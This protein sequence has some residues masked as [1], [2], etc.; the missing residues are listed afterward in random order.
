M[1]NSPTNSSS[2][3]AAAGIDTT[4]GDIEE[5]SSGS[6]WKD[7]FSSSDSEDEDDSSSSGSSDEESSSSWESSSSNSDDESES[8]SDDE[9]D[10]LRNNKQA[11]GRRV[12]NYFVFN[13]GMRF[14]RQNNKNNQE[15]QQYPS[16]SNDSSNDYEKRDQ[17]KKRNSRQGQCK[18][19][20]IFPVSIL[21]KIG[22]KSLVTKK[23][24]VLLIISIFI[25]I[26]IQFLV[27]YH[28]ID[29]DY[30]NYDDPTSSSLSTKSFGLDA[31]IIKEQRRKSALQA[32]GRAALPLFQKKKKQKFTTFD[33]RDRNEQS[34][35][36]PK[37]CNPYS[38]QT[39]SFPNCNDV[40][41]IDLRYALHLSRRGEVIPADLGEGDK[42]G[43]EWK[44]DDKE[45]A[46]R[47]G[48]LGSGLW[49]QVWKVH[50][51][52]D[53]ED[54]V[55]KV[56]KSEHEIDRRNF[57]RHRRDSLVMERLTSSPY[58]VSIFGFCGNTVLTQHGGMTLDEYIFE[59]VKV[60]EKYNRNTQQGKLRLALEVMKGVQSLHGIP[61][62][63]IVH[64]DIQ[65][66]QF[67]FDPEDGRI[68][69]NDFNRCR[70]LPKNNSTGEICKLKIPSAPGSNRSPEEYELMKIDEKI[71]IYSTANVL[72]GILTGQKPYESK[73]RR[74]IRKNVMDGV[75]P[76]IDE[77]F[78]VPGTVDAVLVEIIE[79]TYS[80][81]PEKRWSASTV[82]NK[83]ESLQQISSIRRRQLKQ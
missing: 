28:D 56:M 79:N 22:F 38:W 40:H 57:D 35:K 30:D 16:N 55:L 47:M 36:L 67:L 33:S 26:Y 43:H 2:Y 50:P 10:N 23:S 48:Y 29:L 61:D 80:R 8:S 27:I 71:D 81:D 66:K 14:R 68:R 37:D 63:P 32:L 5:S 31:E 7:K 19:Q 25:W 4:N 49:R 46:R 42:S 82:V 74:E 34:D 15:I 54:A 6:K 20:T 59:D 1:M 72:Y 17:L 77:E 73:M 52:M 75:I 24:T 51:R 58:V 11:I 41:E 64:A 70:F 62:G 44:Q 78:R 83:L 13:S 53:G 60:V 18:K 21:Y 12:E 45:K 65:A 69:I 9:D 39:Y 76:H 3:T